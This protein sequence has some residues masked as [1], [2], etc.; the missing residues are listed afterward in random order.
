MLGRMQVLEGEKRYDNLLKDNP[1]TDIYIYVD[2]IF[3]YKN[4]DTNVK[5]SSVQA[6]SW[7]FWDFNKKDKI[8]QV[9]WI[10][11]MDKREKEC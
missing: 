6:Y 2:R 10:R 3:C 1:P 11:R 4:G 5:M 7:L 8:S 9:H